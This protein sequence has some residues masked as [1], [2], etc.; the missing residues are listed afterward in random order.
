MGGVDN[1]AMCLWFLFFSPEFSSSLQQYNS[2]F[3][4]TELQDAGTC[5]GQTLE[6]RDFSLMLF[7]E[8][9][10]IGSNLHSRMNAHWFH[11][12]HFTDRKMIVHPKPICS[13]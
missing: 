6:K 1:P 10:P 8:K 5:Q 9:P 13:W 2:V 4:K 11:L 12:L 3:L 7:Q